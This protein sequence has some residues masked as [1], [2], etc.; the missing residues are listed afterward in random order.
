MGWLEDFVID[1]AT[2][3]NL[4]IARTFALPDK[5]LVKV[6]RL[7]PVG[8][9]FDVS[10]LRGTADIIIPPDKAHVQIPAR[11]VYLFGDAD[12]VSE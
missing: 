4:K 8:E 12:V 7:E 2:A 5:P 10:I 6:D 9:L 11:E 1:R 3:V